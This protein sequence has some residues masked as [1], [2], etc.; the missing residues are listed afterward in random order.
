MDQF[1]NVT[2]RTKLLALIGSPVGHSG[3]PAMHTYAA[4]LLGLDYVYV[5]FDVPEDRVPQA[6]QAMR[7]LGIRGYNV[8]MPDKIAAAKAVDELS[9]AARIVGACNTIINEDGHLVGHITDGMGYVEN[10]RDHGIDIA[11][12]KITVAGSGGAGTA[13][14]VQCALDGAR[15]VTIFNRRSRSWER[16]LQTAEKIRAARPDCEVRVCDLADTDL[17]TREIAT[18]DIF[19]NA[20]NVGM[21]P[22]LAD[23]SIV[24]DTSALRPG[25]VVTDAVYN[26]L[27][28]RLMREAVEAGCTV[29]G[30][31]GML[32]WQGVAA[33]RLFTGHEMPVQAVKERFYPELL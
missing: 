23:Q 15:A 8:T 25:L 27:N 1:I 5:G 21:A 31:R 14:Q 4:Q 9:D 26:P 10:L 11:G 13:I 3:S 16:A 6:L 18:S 7:T 19:A 28:T 2:G 29:L 12:K 24:R 33:F 22:D 32:L 20:T 17:L 30:G